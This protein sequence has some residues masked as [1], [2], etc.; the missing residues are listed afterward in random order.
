M[1]P[2][3]DQTIFKREKGKL[4]NKKIEAVIEE[5]VCHFCGQSLKHLLN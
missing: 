3:L 5:K 4:T 2:L 1:G